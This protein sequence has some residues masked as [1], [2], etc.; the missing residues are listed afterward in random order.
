M[1]RV[2]A[3]MQILAQGNPGGAPGSAVTRPQEIQVVWLIQGLYFESQS[4][5]N[6]PNLERYRR[7]SLF[8]QT[9]EHEPSFSLPGIQVIILSLKFEI[10]YWF[11][12]LNSGSLFSS[13]LIPC[14]KKNGNNNVDN[15]SSYFFGVLLFRFYIWYVDLHISSAYISYWTHGFKIIYFITF[16]NNI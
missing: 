13:F 10:C 14:R 16:I 9:T 1:S 5:G 2:P 6:E 3:E 11:I 15:I 7:K 8:L 4:L 12:L